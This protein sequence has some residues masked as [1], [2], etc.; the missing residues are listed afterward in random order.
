M[1]ARGA[2]VRAD[3]PAVMVIARDVL[4]A[5]EE[6]LVATAIVPVTADESGVR[7]EGRSRTEISTGHTRRPLKEHTLHLPCHLLAP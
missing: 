2:G 6:L 3:L 7:E 5:R 1:R 4:D